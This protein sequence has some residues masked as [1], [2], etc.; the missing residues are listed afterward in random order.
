MNTQVN[1]SAAPVTGEGLSGARGRG[2]KS[3]G[4]KRQIQDPTFYLGLLREKNTE[5]LAEVEKFKQEQ[6]TFEKDSKL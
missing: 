4:P 2:I 5:L 1:V 6:S 3:A